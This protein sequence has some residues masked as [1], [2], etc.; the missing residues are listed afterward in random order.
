MLTLIENTYVVVGDASGTQLDHTDI[1][2]EGDRIAEVGPALRDKFN[3]RFGDKQV[4]DGQRAIAIPGLINAHL[5]SNESFEQGMS[6]KLP[7]ELWRLRTY[8]A[9]GVPS[10]TEED[11]YLRALMFGMMSIRAGVTTLQDD[12]LNMA[13]TPASVDGAC[14]AYRELGL[15]AWVTTSVGDRSLTESHA[16]LADALPANLGNAVG[17]AGPKSAAEQMDLFERNHDLWDGAE[18]GRIKINIGPRGPQRCSDN[19][20]QRVMAASERHG[21]A[22]H[23]HVLETRPQAVMAQQDYGCSMIEHLAGMGFLSPRL[24]INHGIWLTDNDITLLARNQCKVTHNPLS[25]LKIGSGIYRVRD[26]R[27]AGVTLALGT[28]GLATSDT[29]DMISVL[30]S[31]TMLQN[32]RSPDYD[33]WISAQDGFKIAT[34]GGAASGLMSD[35][36][37]QLSAGWKADLVLLDRRSWSFIPLHDPITQL[38]Y[39]ASPDVVQT[40]IVDGNIVMLNREL[41]TV[42]EARLKDVIF[43]A[44]ERWRCD[45]KPLAL[46]AADRMTPSMAT[47]YWEAIRAFETEEWAAAFHRP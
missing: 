45:I 24:T 5:H 25:N 3:A 6:E 28:D 38:A 31:A 21:C 27:D 26:L 22:V 29:A 36:L 34:R 12:V 15:R 42:D 20:L 17:A 13:C 14:R 11:Y 32:P 43:E 39:S 40:V 2:I 46:A 8:P 47:A 1:L 18:N 16:F 4:V 44:A 7:L 10:L 37:G 35:E 23:T 30:R 9:F 19:L 41:Q 33:T